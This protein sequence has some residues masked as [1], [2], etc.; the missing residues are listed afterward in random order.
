[1]L[2][3]DYFRDERLDTSEPNPGFLGWPTQARFLTVARFGS[4]QKL[5]LMRNAVKLSAENGALHE[6][7]YAIWFCIH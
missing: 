4:E 2:S 1:M 7:A 5:Q 3:G 6:K